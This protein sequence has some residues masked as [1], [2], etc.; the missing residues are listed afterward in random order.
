MKNT[1]VVLARRPAGL[2]REED[3]RVEQSEVPPVGDGQLLVE[4]L[5]FT[6]VATIASCQTSREVSKGGFS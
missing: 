3:F 4:N 1:Q 6:L 5:F 2:P